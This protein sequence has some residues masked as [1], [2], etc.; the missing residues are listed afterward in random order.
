MRTSLKFLL[1]GFMFLAGLAVPGFSQDSTPDLHAK[2]EALV[3]AAYQSAATKFPCKLKA[4]GKAN[5]LRWQDVEKCLNNAHDRVDWA[6]LSRQLQKIRENGRFQAADVSS[7]VESSLS[8][9]AMSYDKVFRV[10]EANALLPLSNSML[11]FLPDDSLLNLPVF[12][13]SGARVGAFSGRYSFEKVGEI[14]GTRN[15]HSLFQYMDLKGNVQS[16]PDKLLLD[17]F[18]VPWKD[19]IAQPGFRLPAD[20]LIPKR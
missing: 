3:S 2:V 6:N 9:Q 18:A 17:S 7:V 5:M 14:S 11:K 10:K 16:P 20:R 12:N 4:R 15:R 8:A 13:N 19:A 1:P